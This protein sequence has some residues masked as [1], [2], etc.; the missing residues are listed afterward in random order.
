MKF[1]S[2]LEK[3][4]SLDKPDLEYSFE[5]FWKWKLETEHELDYIL[6]KEHV[7]IA[8]NKLS[9]TLKK[10]RWARSNQLNNFEIFAPRLHD[11]LQNIP[12]L[13]NHIRRYSLLDIEEMPV[14]LLRDLWD[15]IGCVKSLEK[16]ENGWYLV[17]A[18]TKPLV[19]LWGQTPAFD[20]V[21][22]KAM[23]KFGMSGLTANRWDF[24]TWR[25]VLIEFKRELEEQEG[26][27]EF[28]REISREEYGNDDVVPY[29][30]FLDL[31]YW[32][33][34]GKTSCHH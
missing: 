5:G 23:P 6:D 10:W 27:I 22:R 19:F 7:D 9:N 18:A 31:Y 14:Q 13:Y 26:L 8:F 28:F 3:F 24:K 20:D 17:M 32:T 2:Q 25:D 12:E 15:N 4:K 16:N 34:K 33:N 11:C 21:V 29:G 30:Q 1:R